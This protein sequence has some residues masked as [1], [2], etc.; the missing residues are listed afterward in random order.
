MQSFFENRPTRLDTSL[1]SVRH[2][3]ELIRTRT[4]VSL[5]LVGGQE[6]EGVIKWQDNHFLALR[7]TANQPLMMV[8]REAITVLRAL[9]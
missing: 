3:Q 2:I 1:P 7:Q 4:V 9:L 5:S 6:V 8:N